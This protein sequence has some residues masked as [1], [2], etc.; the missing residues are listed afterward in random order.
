MARRSVHMKKSV[1]SARK[2][3]ALPASAFAVPSERKYP[4]N[5]LFHARLALTY[6]LSPS[7]AE[8]RD[9]VVRAV[10]AKYPELRFWWE[11]RSK[12][13]A[14]PARRRIAARK[15]ANPRMRRNGDEEWM[16]E[17]ELL[18]QKQRKAAQELFRSIGPN[19]GSNADWYDPAYHLGGDLFLVDSENGTLD[20]VR[21]GP[22]NADEEMYDDET[23]ARFYTA[24][25]AAAYL[26]KH[27]IRK[28]PRRMENPVSNLDVV[29]KAISAAYKKSWGD[30]I[31][32][33]TLRDAVKAPKD[34]KR[35]SEEGI[36]GSQAVVFTEYGGLSQYD[37]HEFWSELKRELR[38]HGL[39]YEWLDGGT[40]TIRPINTRKTANPSSPS[41]EDYMATY[42]MPARRRL[43]RNSL[44]EDG[45]IVQSNPRVWRV[46][47]S[48]VQGPAHESR[49]RGIV[50]RWGGRL[51]VSGGDHVAT[52]SSEDDAKH[53]V[54][55][56][57]DWGFGGQVR[58]GMKKNPGHRAAARH[59][60]RAKKPTRMDALRADAARAGY[61]VDAYSPGDGVTRYRFFKLSDLE[62]HGIDPREQNYFGPASGVHTALGLAAANTFLAGARANPRR[63]NGLS[64]DG[65]IVQSNPRRR[66]AARRNPETPSVLWKKGKWEIEWFDAKNPWRGFLVNDGWRSDHVT[67]YEP[68][69]V[70]Y[71]RPE[72]VPAY[73]KSAVIQLSKKYAAEFADGNRDWRHN[74]RRRNPDPFGR[75][76]A[77]PIVIGGP[78]VLAP[79]PDRPIIMSPV[80]LG[81]KGGGGGTSGGGSAPGGTASGGGG[82]STGTS[83]PAARANPRRKSARSRAAQSDAK[84]AMDLFHSGKAKTLAA[85]WKMVKR[86]R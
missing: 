44:S 73:V 68:G 50:T 64:E 32:A 86:G 69:K 79:V 71:D 67:V 31:S 52:F 4:I 82:G 6:V 66:A 43:R 63:R 23:V 2:R 25:E 33:S 11:S 41:Y 16:D 15:V 56:A 65:L 19:V 49:L 24:D 28:N 77:G 14:A 60:P 1:L 17:D 84:R 34:T 36:V 18:H 26:K 78:P 58:E 54:R 42:V 39:Y 85:A 45:M 76:S 29:R 8:Y 38:L 74:P 46:S 72:I 48:H 10:L 3:R 57:G 81:G 37:N 21:R 59:N 30:N 55:Q 62:R 51:R 80:D 53:A 83:A 70:A 47:F 27:G 9:E 35:R 75:G 22:W 5:D 20:I 61:L 13:L 40:A 12:R 7:N